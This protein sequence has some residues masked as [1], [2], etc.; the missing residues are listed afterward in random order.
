MSV[1]A[2]TDYACTSLVGSVPASGKCLAS[3]TAK[4]G[5][6]KAVCNS[7]STA[8]GDAASYTP[9]ELK[10]RSSPRLPRIRQQAENSS[11]TTP[12]TLLTTSI[13]E[14]T[15]T[16]VASSVASQISSGISA[17]ANAT[18]TALTTPSAGAQLSSVISSGSLIN[19]NL[20]SYVTYT[21]NASAIYTGTL[22]MTT[23]TPHATVTYS[24]TTNSNGSA[25]LH[26]GMA[27]AQATAN[28]RVLVTVLAGMAALLFGAV[29]L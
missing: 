1:L 14:D 21:G 2:Y 24:G 8:S 10:R 4:I 20:T 6:W 9:S 23:T 5:S 7:S 28:G 16:A 13:G 11:V 15:R 3:I 18:I 29:A 25:T 19:A 22:S 17:D 26:M 12:T 27:S